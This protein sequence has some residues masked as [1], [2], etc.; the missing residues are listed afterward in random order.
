MGW[1]TTSERRGATPRLFRNKRAA[2]AADGLND[3]TLAADGATEGNR[4]PGERLTR[5]NGF[6]MG[7][8]PRAIDR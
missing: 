8:L 2:T 6:R 4:S 3:R 1:A 7:A 5:S